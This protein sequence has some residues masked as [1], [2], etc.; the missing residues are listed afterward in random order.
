MCALS[1]WRGTRVAVDPGWV[2]VSPLPRDHQGFSFPQ[3][4]KGVEVSP[5]SLSPPSAPRQWGEW[6]FLGESNESS[7]EGKLMSRVLP[8][9]T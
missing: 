8:T 7:S 2:A 9:S 6:G 1:L 3:E 5:V 4:E